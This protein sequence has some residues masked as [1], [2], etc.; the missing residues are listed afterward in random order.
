VIEIRGN[1]DIQR[2]PIGSV[3]GATQGRSDPGIGRPFAAALP[4]HSPPLLI[5]DQFPEEY[6]TQAAIPATLHGFG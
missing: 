4:L 3:S 1:L 6:S 2:Q 5:F